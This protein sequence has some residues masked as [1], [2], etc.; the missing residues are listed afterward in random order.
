MWNYGNYTGKSVGRVLHAL[1][2]Y[3]NQSHIVDTVQV[4]DGVVTFHDK[5]FAT[6]VWEENTPVLTFDQFIRADRY[7][8][9][10]YFHK[11]LLDFREISC[12][13]DYC[14]QELSKVISCYEAEMIVW[15]RDYVSDGIIPEDLKVKIQKHLISSY[16]NPILSDKLNDL[17]WHAALCVA[18][19]LTTSN[20]YHFKVGEK[21]M[22]A[23]KLTGHMSSQYPMTVGNVYTVIGRDGSNIITTTDNIMTASFNPESVVRVRR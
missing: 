5:P 12:T 17:W 2:V 4:G 1:E 16:G 6:Y 18:Y 13:F 23:K 20:E 19:N 15:K 22:L 14:I 8:K 11:P 21:V 7:C 9:R 3:V 10:Q